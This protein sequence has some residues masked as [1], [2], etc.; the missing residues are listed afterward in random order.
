MAARS[1]AM[2]R[3]GNKGTVAV[4][5]GKKKRVIS[6]GKEGRLAVYVCVCVCVCV[7]EWSDSIINCSLTFVCMGWWCRW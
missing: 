4:A 6:L 2:K 1:R 3:V 5:D 7:C